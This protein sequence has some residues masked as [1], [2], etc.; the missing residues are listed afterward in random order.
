MR[1]SVS[2]CL[3]LFPCVERKRSENLGNSAE[4]ERKSREVSEVLSAIAIFINR[5]KRRDRT[6][7][8]PAVSSYGIT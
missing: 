5:A 7:P 8:F 4:P 2:P 6:A 1:W 3:H